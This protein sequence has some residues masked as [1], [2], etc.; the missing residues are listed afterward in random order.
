MQAAAAGSYVVYS[1]A[2]I[3]D[4]PEK[5]LALQAGHKSFT[6]RLFCSKK[7]QKAP[8]YVMLYANDNTRSGFESQWR[9]TRIY[10]TMLLWVTH[11][12]VSE[13][14]EHLKAGIA[15]CGRLIGDYHSTSY[16]LS[17]NFLT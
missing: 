6:S 16:T 17:P 1:F 4:T 9:V 12:G 11:F 2:L 10:H 5:R 7:K 14:L 3:P 15:F 13:R 8:D